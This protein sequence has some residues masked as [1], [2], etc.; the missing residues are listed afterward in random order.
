MTRDELQERILTILTEDF[1]FEN[2][3]LDDNLRDDHNFDSIDAIELLGKIEHILDK[4]LTREE[5]EQ[6][7]E[8][9]TINDIL[10][11]IEKLTGSSPE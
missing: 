4:T 10:D 6:A 7:M 8:I 3:G 11:Y 2:P 1:E 9:R 5:K